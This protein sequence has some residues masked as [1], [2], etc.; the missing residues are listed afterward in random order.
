MIFAPKSK[1]EN[2]LNIKI[3]NTSI[4]RVSVTKFLGVILTHSCHGNITLSVLI[5]KSRSVLELSLKQGRC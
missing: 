2:D 1:H 3:Q 4:E 5:K